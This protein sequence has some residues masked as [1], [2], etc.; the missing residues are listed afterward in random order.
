MKLPKYRSPRKIEKK[1]LAFIVLSNN[2]GSPLRKR[3]ATGTIRIQ[4]SI[5]GLITAP[6]YLAGHNGIRVKIFSTIKPSSVINFFGI[7]RS[8]KQYFHPFFKVLYYS[9]FIIS[10]QF[11]LEG[12]WLWYTAFHNYWVFGLCSSSGILETRKHNVPETGSVFVLRWG[13]KHILC[14]V[15]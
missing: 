12:L 3:F 8:R 11:P 14:W 15:P 1:H 2:L 9:I 10:G 13:R 5:F 7:P 6:W 4:N